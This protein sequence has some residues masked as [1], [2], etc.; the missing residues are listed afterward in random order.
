MPFEASDWSHGKNEAGFEVPVRLLGKS[1]A[2]SEVFPRLA[3]AEEGA[4]GVL[5]SR[6]PGGWG[7]SI[8]IFHHFNN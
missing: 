4:S 2:G 1:K 5:G 7:L 8:W 3:S 6:E